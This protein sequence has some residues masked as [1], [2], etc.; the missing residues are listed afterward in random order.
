MDVQLRVTYN[1]MGELETEWVPQWGDKG[2]EVG[3]DYDTLRNL[4]SFA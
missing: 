2:W 4:A 1:F 3:E